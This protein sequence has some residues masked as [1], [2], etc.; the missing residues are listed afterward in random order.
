MNLQ[1][2]LNNLLGERVSAIFVNSKRNYVDVS[3]IKGLRGRL[4][5]CFGG[6]SIGKVSVP[7]YAIVEMGDNYDMFDLVINSDLF[8]KNVIDAISE[9]RK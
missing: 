8:D 3:G 1:T 7:S 6:Y 5:P 4:M 9:A 2:E